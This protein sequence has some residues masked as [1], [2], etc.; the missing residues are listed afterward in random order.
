VLAMYETQATITEG[1]VL[2]AGAL[3]AGIALLVYLER[4]GLGDRSSEPAEPVSDS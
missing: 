2:G 1:Y 4:N 3:V